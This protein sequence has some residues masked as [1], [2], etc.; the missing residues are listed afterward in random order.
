MIRRF[1][2]F[3]LKYL[4]TAAKRDDLLPEIQERMKTDPEGSSTGVYLITSLYFDTPDFAFFRSKIDGIKYRRKLRIRAYGT[5]AP[6]SNPTVMVEIKQR[7][8]RTVQKRR[9][10]LPLEHAYALCAGTAP[11]LADARDAEVAAEVEFLVRSMHLVPACT[12][13]YVRQAFMGGI[14]EPGLRVTFDYALWCKGSS[15]GL[16]GSGDRYSLLA[17]N[18]VVLEVKAN[19]AV[20]MW[21]S[22]MLAR[23]SVSLSRFSKYCAGLARLQEISARRLHG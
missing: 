2:R 4:I 15:G 5:P 14:Y 9:L 17:P 12:I 13:S 7:I 6:D 3:E 11:P 8:N 23:H 1:N 19:D 21:V 16:L 10:A 22:R 20:P 18:A